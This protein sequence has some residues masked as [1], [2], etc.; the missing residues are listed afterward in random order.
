MKKR[1]L[2]STFSIIL[3]TIFMIPSIAYA[4]VES[5]NLKEA[6]AEE[7]EIF[8]SEESYA[9]QVEQLKSYDL[10]GY[11]ENNKKVNVYMFRGSSCSHCFEA[12]EHFA[13]IY[14][15]SGKYFNLVTYEV[16]N[17]ADNNSLMED[18]AGEL[19][20]EA[21]GVP[22]IV[23]GDK[24][25]SGYASSYDDEMMSKIKSEFKKSTEKRTDIVKEVSSDDYSKDYSNDIV[26]LIIILV[27]V[28]GIVCGIIY[29]RK[30]TTKK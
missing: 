6:V 20:E 21:S 26:A 24:S 11:T 27:V 22:F 8:G 19:G 17:N 29:T 14:G 4:K 28:A 2:I 25:W 3:M 10:S 9:E 7:I 30:N 18:V 1:F 23:I 16:W 5:T 12:I 15:E 13:S